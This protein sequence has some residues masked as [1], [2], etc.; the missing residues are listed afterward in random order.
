[1]AGLFRKLKQ[2][3][4]GQKGAAD[5]SSKSEKTSNEKNAARESQGDSHRIG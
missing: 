4:G 1:M 2:T 5:S 3:L